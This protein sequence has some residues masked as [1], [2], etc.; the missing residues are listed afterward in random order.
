MIRF[1]SAGVEIIENRGP[2]WEGMEGWVIAPEPS[3]SIG[4][5]AGDSPASFSLVGG[6]FRDAQGRIFALDLFAR[7]LRVF[8][9]DGSFLYAAGGPG[10][11]PG[12]FPLF[13]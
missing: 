6:A 4:D 12:E 11:G 10:E 9:P 3:V 1:D 5:R 8:S 7:E 2:A 13:P